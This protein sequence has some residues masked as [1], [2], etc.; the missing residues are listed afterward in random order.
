MAEFYAQPLKLVHNKISRKNPGG[1]EIDRFRGIMPGTD[2][3]RTEAW[4]GSCIR[5]NNFSEQSDKNTGMAK[6]KLPDSRIVYVQEFIDM[7]PEK[8]LGEEHS[9]NFG[10]NPNL[11]VKLIDP[12]RQSVLQAHPNRERAKKAFHSEFGKTE[13]WYILSLRDD[14]PEKPYILLGFMEGVTREAFEELYEKEDYAKMADLCH[15]ITVQPD[16]MYFIESGMIHSIGSC[17]FIE[18]QEPSD[19]IAKVFKNPKYPQGPA[20]WKERELG[21]FLYEG[22][23]YEDNLKKCFVP[24]REL[25][26]DRY[27]VEQYLIGSGQTPYFGA[28]RYLITGLFE[29]M[30]TGTFSIA[31]ILEGSGVIRY[32]GGKLPV[33]KGDEVFLPAGI[34]KMAFVNNTAGERLVIVRCLPPGVI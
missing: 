15:K 17:F 8:I 25:K 7:D 31:L 12:Q 30:Q 14:A 11:L 10:N 23:S 2:D 5:V 24:R 28:L 9:K 13:C 4:I 33:C 32:K 29:P 21:T 22:K 18:I 16:E 20:A 6:V 1:K 3:G 19:V 26:K 27:G 34:E